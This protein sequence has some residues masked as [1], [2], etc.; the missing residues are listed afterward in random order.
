MTDEQ[1]QINQDVLRHMAVDLVE[2]Y[3]LPTV[4]LF[5]FYN[6]HKRSIRMFNSCGGQ[7]FSQTD[8]KKIFTDTPEK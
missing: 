2:Q 8:N 5:R 1:Q 7:Y 4:R 3:F 6:F